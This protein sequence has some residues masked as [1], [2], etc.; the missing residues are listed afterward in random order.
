MKQNTTYNAKMSQIL[1]MHLMHVPRKQH[2]L[3]PQLWPYYPRKS[4]IPVMYR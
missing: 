1:T 2:Y 3:G 4:L